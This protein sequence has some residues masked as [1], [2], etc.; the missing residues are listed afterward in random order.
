[1]F[2][3][4][5]E[6]V[7]QYIFG[8]I[9]LPLLPSKGRIEKNSVDVISTDESIERAV[10]R[11]EELLST[12]S[13][14]LV[15]LLFRPVAL[16]VFLL[17]VYAQGTSHTKMG[18]R[19]IQLLGSYMASSSSPA[20]DVLHLVERL[21]HIATDEGW[22]FTAGGEGGIAIRRTTDTDILS[23]GFD[24]IAR[25][26]SVLIEILRETS[27]DVKTEVF[28]GVIRRW[29]SPH[30]DDDFLPYIIFKFVL[31]P[32]R[33]QMYN[34]YRKFCQIISLNYSNLLRV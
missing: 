3:R 16:N 27:D 1:M 13:L 25:R 33:S 15:S 12:P 17:S 2:I 20:I 30:H 11:L 31:T 34:C 21:S 6:L 7:D 23:L 8:P 24:D 14:T 26:I 28:V 9:R 32:G 4:H 5:A 18:E 19:T 10:Q 22:T 29:L